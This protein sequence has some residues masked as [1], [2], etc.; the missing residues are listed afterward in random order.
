M[1]AVLC[2]QYGAPEVLHIQDISRPQ[3]TDDEVLVKIH[4][5]TVTA[6]DGMMRKGKPYIGRLAIGLT[7]PKHP[8]TGTGFAGEVIAVGKE[9]AEFKIGDRVFGES[10]LGAGTNAEYICV[11]EGGVI[12]HIPQDKDYEE[13][14]SVCDGPLTSLNLLRDLAKIQEGQRVLIIGASGSLG[15]AAVQLAKHFGAEVTGLCSGKNVE[16]VYSLGADHVIDYT[17]SDF[18]QQ[19]KQ[20]DIIYDSVGKSSFSAAKASLTEYGIFLSPVLRFADLFHML[21]TSLFG[22]KKVMFA[23]TGMR[24]KSELRVLL[25]EL[26]N[27]IEAGELRTIIDR[28]YPLSQISDAHRYVDTGHKKGNI[29]I[30]V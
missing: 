10:V 24:A 6:A 1:K 28:R 12:A 21:R 18:T 26:K 20:Y 17:V 16:M 4:A 15:T 19:D 13:V 5:S 11:P 25:H 23:A 30:T 14:A 27:L 29:V 22:K 3:P 2:T 8:I 7:K 9:V